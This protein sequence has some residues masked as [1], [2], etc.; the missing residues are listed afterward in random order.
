MKFCSQCASPVALRI[1][2]GDNRPRFTCDQCGTIHYSNPNIVAG[3]IAEHE[4]A[5]ILCQRAIEPR[6]GLWTLP[7][8]FMENNETVEE[9]A[10]RETLEEANAHV[11]RLQLY[12]MYSIPHISQVYMMFR[13]R[14]LNTDF[15]PGA[16]SLAVE[17]FREHEIPW[18]EIA[19][20]VIRETLQRYFEQKRSGAFELLSGTILPSAKTRT[21]STG[22]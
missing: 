4:D 1:P 16:E 20:P 7:A 6:R 11:D 14:L 2:E 3:C 18:D 9:G 8:G 5:I 13:S 15:G 19:F 10:M 22:S 21:T 12:A 17:L